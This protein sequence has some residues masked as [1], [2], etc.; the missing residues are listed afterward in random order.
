MDKFLI[1][2]TG[3]RSTGKTTMAMALANAEP[4]RGADIQ[5]FADAV[6]DDVHRMI[7]E[8]AGYTLSKIQKAALK[9][10]SLGHMYQ[11]YGELA[12]R[13]FGE[14]FWIKRLEMVLSDRAIIHDVRY[15]NE[16]EWIKSR[17]GLL[18]GVV[19]EIRDLQDARDERHPSEV[20]VSECL[21]M[22]DVMVYNKHGYNHLIQE[23]VRIAED[24][25]G[26]TP[27]QVAV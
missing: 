23:S 10:N 3:Y 12:R 24:I 21:K 27:E 5:G 9:A 22:A 4:L 15:P 20:F 19:G 25:V 6:K 13:L 16:A 1:G 17:G 11:G 26:V 18:I 8:K 2:I 7:E 14:D